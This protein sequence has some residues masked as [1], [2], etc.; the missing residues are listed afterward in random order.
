M[1]AASHENLKTIR[2]EGEM[3]PKWAQ[4]LDVAARLCP[5]SE[6][7]RT[8]F[9][10]FT[11]ASGVDDA[12]TVLHEIGTLKAA[13]REHRDVL[14]AELTKTEQHHQALTILAAWEYSLET[15]AQQASPKKTCSWQVEGLEDGDGTDFG[16]G[17]V[18]LRRV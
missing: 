2:F 7:T 17:D 12:Q 13:L 9:S 1:S 11:R 3:L 4:L 16:D 8:W 6:P 18:T 10:R 15:M 5:I 14:V